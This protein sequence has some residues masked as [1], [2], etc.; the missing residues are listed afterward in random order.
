MSAASVRQ[1]LGKHPDKPPG[2][3]AGKGKWDR[4]LKITTTRNPFDAAVSLYYWRRLAG[5]KTVPTDFSDTRAQ[6]GSMLKSI[7]WELDF[8]VTHIDGQYV[9]DQTIR[10]ETLQS[11]FNAVWNKI[12]PESKAV[13]LPVRKRTKHRRVQQVADFYDAEA[14]E[15]VL[16]GAAWIFDRFDYPRVPTGPG[17]SGPQ[18]KE[19]DQ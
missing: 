6:F 4:Y 1:Q 18:L 3:H 5:N 8:L 7:N 15:I 9:P 17:Q 14:I 2:Q 12:A 13:D 19:A 10:F 16:K 11:D